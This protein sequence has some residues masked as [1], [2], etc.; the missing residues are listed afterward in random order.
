[1]LKK[2]AIVCSWGGMRCSYTG[3]FLVGLGRRFPD[4]KPDIMIA[5]SGWAGCAS[6]YLTDQLWEMERI[7][8]THLANPGTINPLKIQKMMSIDYAIDDVL[9]I[10]EPLHTAKMLESET[11]WYI[12]VTQ[13]SNQA[14]VYFPQED[15]REKDHIYDLIQ[16]SMSVPLLYGKEK[17]LYGTS[18]VDGGFGAPFYKTVKKAI[19]LGATQILAIDSS[20][21]QSE[22]IDSL[23]TE[24]VNIELIRNPKIPARLLSHS[25]KILTDSFELGL[26]DAM[27]HSWLDAFFE[28]ITR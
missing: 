14:P 6:Y 27:D 22:D 26:R 20:R 9:R 8:T 10:R 28:R 4:F 25:E 24:G 16:A 5:T 13:V 7:W 19:E 3:G 12:V 21:S 11:K 23:R 15:I 2:I 17:I 18:Y 1:M